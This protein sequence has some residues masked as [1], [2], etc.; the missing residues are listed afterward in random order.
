MIH[1][2]DLRTM[3]ASEYS[4]GWLYSKERNTL[5]SLWWE[6]LFS[7]IATTSSIYIQEVTQNF[8]DG[9]QPTTPFM[10]YYNIISKA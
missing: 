3:E 8:S 7:F 1:A 4:N 6:E 2:V 5:E 10:V 9:V